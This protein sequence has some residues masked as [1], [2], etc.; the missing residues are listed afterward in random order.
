MAIIL[1]INIVGLIFLISLSGYGQA[2][3]FL[4]SKSKYER[5]FSYRILI[6]L[7]F[8][9]FILEFIHLFSPVN[10]AISLTLIFLG[11]FFSYIASYLYRDRVDA[12]SLKAIFSPNGL[13]LKLIFVVICLEIGVLASP[14]NPDTAGYH[15]GLVDLIKHYPIIPGIGNL[16]F[17]LGFNQS[18]F[19][20]SAFIDSLYLE[21][22]YRAANLYIAFVPIMYTIYLVQKKVIDKKTVIFLI[23]PIVISLRFVSSPSPDLYNSMVQLLVFLLFL[24]IFFVKNSTCDQGYKTFIAL[25]LIFSLFINKLSGIFFALPFGFYL[26]IHLYRLNQKRYIFISL[27][28]LLLLSCIHFYRGYVQT[29]Y[30]FF[31]SSIFGNEGLAWSVPKKIAIAEQAW[32]YSWARQPNLSPEI[33]LNGYA[34]VYPW[35]KNSWFQMSILCVVVIANIYLL[36]NR[37]CLDKNKYHVLLVLLFLLTLPIIPWFYTAPDWRFLGSI[38]Y[39]MLSCTVTQFTLFT[40]Y[41]QRGSVYKK[42]AFFSASTFFLIISILVWNLRKAEVDFSGWKPLPEVTYSV[43]KTSSGLKINVPDGPGASCWLIPMPCTPYFN[44]KLHSLDDFDPD[45]LKNGLSVK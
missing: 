11:L 27:F 10:S 23:L 6:G 32:I 43:R 28:Y 2:I 20:Y 24:D 45:T 40:S 39:L 3:G 19:S 25:I 18:Y 15:L 30:P 41:T 37:K 5:H 22:G 21:N 42:I 9:I 4:V 1:Y 33:V 31:P 36:I 8:L 14:G 16:H 34:W 17:R 38:P 35:L 44:S 7:P 26:Y 29:G 12:S 13:L